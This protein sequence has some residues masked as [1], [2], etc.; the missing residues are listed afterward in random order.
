M[1]DSGFEDFVQN[2]NMIMGG[3]PLDRKFLTG[4]WDGADKDLNRAINHLM[5]TD[6]SKLIREGQAGQADGASPKK[7]KK[8]GERR[9][10]SSKASKDRSAP[11]DFPS[12][13]FS[14]AGGPDQFP[15]SVFGGGS[16]GDS[17]FAQM[18]QGMP[19]VQST[20]Q[21]MQPQMQPQ[22]PPYTQTHMP[23]HMQPQPPNMQPQMM[24]PHMQPQ[25]PP[26]MQPQ[27]QHY[28]DYGQP[29][30]QTY[31]AQPMMPPYNTQYQQPVQ[32]FSGHQQQPSYP[33]NPQPTTQSFGAPSQ[34]MPQQAQT[35]PLQTQM[36]PQMSPAM[37][38]DGYGALQNAGGMQ[39][40]TSP[41]QLQLQK[42]LEELD[43]QMAEIQKA[44]QVPQVNDLSHHAGPPL[45]NNSGNVGGFNSSMAGLQSGL[46]DSRHQ[47]YN[48][49]N[50]SNAADESDS[51]SDNDWWHNPPSL[52]STPQHQSHY[53][54][55]GLMNM[56]VT[57][58]GPPRMY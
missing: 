30:M 5:G 36:H 52:S 46:P 20:T 29:T 49:F 43:R 15:S 56:N 33:G 6:E 44:L 34:F 21:F 8:K 17:G 10:S 23:P 51:D 26:H 39:N 31:G 40:S 37:Q 53:N 28:G 16:F 57:V 47:D 25:M 14:S 48:S 54:G 9:S 2:A 42:E 38:S 41:E 58:P 11:A 13:P 35:P 1:A 24:P 32:P 18:S 4:I 27:G 12:D 45:S 22:M 19:P 55:Q 7:D 3:A 50:Y